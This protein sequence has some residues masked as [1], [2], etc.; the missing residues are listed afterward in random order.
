[1]AAVETK[2]CPHVRLYFTK[3]SQQQL[4]IKK[5]LMIHRQICIYTTYSHLLL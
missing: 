2:N 1:M 5:L 3:D 4:M